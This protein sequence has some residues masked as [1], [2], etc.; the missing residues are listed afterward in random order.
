[1]CQKMCRKCVGN[2]S[3]MCRTDGRTDGRLEF[4]IGNNK[5]LLL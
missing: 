3:E 4:Y 2:V 1:M 5:G